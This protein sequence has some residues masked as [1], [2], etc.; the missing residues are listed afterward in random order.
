MVDLKKDRDKSFPDIEDWTDPQNH[1]RYE[2]N[3]KKLSHKE[4]LWFHP[5]AYN[6]IT[7]GS[8]FIGLLMFS[9]ISI[10]LFLIDMYFLASINGIM[11]AVLAFTAI[12]KVKEYKYTKD[13]TLY[14]IFLRDYINE[15][16][17]NE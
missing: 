2:N 12:K 6:L 8:V 14:D 13:T 5:S 17:K 1:I 3:V 9:V 10:W 4:W 7:I 16:D 15:D 11:I